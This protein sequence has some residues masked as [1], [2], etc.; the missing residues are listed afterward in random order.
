M[1]DIDRILLDAVQA[2]GRRALSALAAEVGLST[3]AVTS[4]CGGWPPTAC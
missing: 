4:G 3:S 1:D 2:D